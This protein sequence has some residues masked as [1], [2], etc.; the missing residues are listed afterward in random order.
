MDRAKTRT[1]TLGSLAVTILLASACAGPSGAPPN[2]S[3]G[4]A[5]PAASSGEAVTSQ[6]GTPVPGVAVAAGALTGAGST[7][8]NPLM[9]KWSKEYN[10]LHSNV[11]INYQSIGSGGGIQQFLAK[12]ISFGASDAPLNDDQ[13][14]QAGGATAALHVPATMGSEAITYNLQGVQSMKLTGDVLANIYLGAVT[15][16]NDPA[17]AQLNGGVNLPNT[18]IAVVHRSDG[19]GT[20]DIFTDY[21]SKISPDW[22]SRVGRGTSVNWPTGIGGQGNEGVT[23]QVKLTNG[24]LGYVELAYA[25]ANNLPYAQMKNHDGNFVN[26]TIDTTAAAASTIASSLPDDLRYSITD[27]SGAQAYPIAGTTWLLVYK[28]QSDPNAGRT[29][30]QFAWWAIHDGQS[31]SKD[32]NY[33]ALPPEL[34]KRS[35]DQLKKMQCGSGPCAQL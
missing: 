29:L 35:E 10:T 33:A 30:G 3:T 14:N 19:S 34:A 5:P 27:A 25:L 17:I 26:P 11:T 20:T 22:K 24:G 16:W 6:P 4:G 8:I 23:N 1:R 13:F 2:A 18:A 32:L 9:S 15:R 31:F 7:F 28:D 12:T 21:L